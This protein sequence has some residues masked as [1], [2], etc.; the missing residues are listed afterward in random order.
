[1]VRGAIYTRWSTD[2]QRQLK[3][4]FERKQKDRT[5]IGGRN[6]RR[7]ISTLPLIHP[8]NDGDG[9]RRFT[10]STYHTRARVSR[11]IVGPQTY[12]FIY[13][14]TLHTYIYLFIY[15]HIYIYIHNTQ[16]CKSRTSMNF[17][18]FFFF[19]FFYIIRWH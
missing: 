12:Q 4:L 16:V 5:S 17:S 2:E 19:N 6:R 15:V 8:T 10:P 7:I 9:V 14:F 13:R 18:F 11:P 3:Q 1:M